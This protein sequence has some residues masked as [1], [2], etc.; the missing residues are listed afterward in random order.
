MHVSPAWAWIKHDWIIMILVFLIQTACSLNQNIN[1]F[2]LCVLRSAISSM[3]HEKIKYINNNADKLPYLLEYFSGSVS[4]SGNTMRGIF[5][6]LTLLL[7][8]I[9]RKK[10]ICLRWVTQKLPLIVYDYL[11]IIMIISAIR[12]LCWKSVE[13]ASIGGRQ[14][15][16]TVNL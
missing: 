2:V 3:I 8:K 16:S 15:T 5:I 6:V 9:T 10:N 12:C 1:I 4:L 13:V 11:F 7:S 14:P